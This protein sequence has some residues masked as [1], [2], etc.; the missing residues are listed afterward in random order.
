M[1]DLSQVKYKI[2]NEDSNQYIIN[3]SK[4]INMQNNQN[5]PN[6]GQINESQL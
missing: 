6:G 5:A 2:I 4:L 3:L 1:I